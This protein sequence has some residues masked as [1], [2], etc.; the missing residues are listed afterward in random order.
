MIDIS[1]KEFKQLVSYVKSSYG[2]D[3][4][5]KKLLVMTRLQNVLTEKGFNSFDEYYKYIISDKSGDSTITLLNKLTTN[6]TF[7]LRENEHFQ[8]FGNVVLPYLQH[9]VKDMDLRI[10]SAGCSSGQEPYTLAMILEDYC[11][12]NNLRWDKK[13]LATDISTQAL[14]KA[15]DGV[16]SSEELEK[17]PSVWKLNYMKADENNNYKIADK[18]KQEVIFRRFNL[19][20]NF[21]F[22]KKFHVIFCRNVMIYFDNEVKN[23]LI[24]K[25]YDYIE[26]GGYLFIG[27]SETLNFSETKFRCIKPAIYRKE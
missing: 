18:I 8:Y 21:P 4:F 27:H 7:F 15:Q 19:M 6:H 13:V 25:F 14:T 24:N 16:Y 17:I 11:R 2:I 26:D 10:W 22:K 5:R 12:E 9:S 3:L 20:N 1:E 23:N